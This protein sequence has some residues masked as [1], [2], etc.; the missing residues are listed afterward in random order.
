LI[1]IKYQLNDKKLCNEQS[2]LMNQ[3]SLRFIYFLLTMV[4]ILI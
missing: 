2:H 4:K 1:V 3:S